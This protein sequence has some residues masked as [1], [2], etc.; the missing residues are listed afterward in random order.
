MTTK[1]ILFFVTGFYP[2]KLKY[3]KR[4]G[5]W[6]SFSY[7]EIHCLFTPVFKHFNNFLYWKSLNHFTFVAFSGFS[8]KH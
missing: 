2:I 3:T 4:D 6:P 1:V 5:T 8:H 7:G